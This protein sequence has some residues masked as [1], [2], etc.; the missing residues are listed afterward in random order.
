MKFVA[1]RRFDLVLTDLKMT[2]MS[3]LDLLKELT[4]FDK[5]DFWKAQMVYHLATAKLNK[6]QFEF[7]VETIPFLTVKAFDFPTVG[8]QL[9]N[10]E[11]KALNSLESKALELFSREEAFAI[12]MGLG[13][14]KEVPVSMDWYETVRPMGCECR[15]WCG[16]SQICDGYGCAVTQSECGMFDS[17]PCTQFCS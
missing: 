13:L 4:D 14:H 8:G 6:A 15:W 16:A 7:I 12:F 2:G 10:E 11:T 9:K 17:S 5:S 3:G 1:D